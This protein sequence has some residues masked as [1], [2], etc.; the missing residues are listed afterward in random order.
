MIRKQLKPLT[1][2]FSN[3]FM[4]L[5][6]SSISCA[7]ALILLFSSFW[8][9]LALESSSSDTTDDS[10]LFVGFFFIFKYRLKKLNIFAN[11]KSLVLLQLTTI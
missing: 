5:F 10:F 11:D 6:R 2:S 4:R 8:I 1:K 9:D 7:C 3:L